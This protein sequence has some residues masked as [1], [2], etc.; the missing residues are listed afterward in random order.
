VTLIG[1]EN[2][3]AS[4]LAEDLEV[5]FTPP[6]KTAFPKLVHKIGVVKIEFSKD[7][8]YK[9]GYDKYE[10]MP[11]GY[12]TGAADASVKVEPKYD[13]VSIEKSKEGKVKATYEGADAADIFF[14]A[15]APA[16]AKP[17][18]ENP[19]AS[20]FDLVITG[21]GINRGETLIEGRVESK[22]GP[23]VAKLG[24]VVFLKV[25]VEAEFYAVSDLLSAPTAVSQHAV[26]KEQLNG[27][28]DNAYPAAIAELKIT[29]CHDQNVNYD[30]APENGILDLIATG[31]SAEE[32]K[33]MTDCAF[34]LTKQNIVCVKDLQ[35]LFALGSDLTLKKTGTSVLTLTSTPKFLTVNGWFYIEDKNG[36]KTAIVVDSFNEPAKTVTVHVHASTPIA[37]DMAF[38]TANQ[39]QILFP[40]NGL[41][42]NPGWVRDQTGVEPLANVIGHEIGHIKFGF[43][44]ICEKANLMYYMAVGGGNWGL[45]HRKVPIAYDPFGDEEQWNTIPGR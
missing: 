19:T 1:T 45:R 5:V 36:Q 25:T 15:A 17:K 35:W 9:G 44:D 6:G 23:I 34:D 4:A 14:T 37:A 13:F 38:T 39:S 29:A 20:P 30:T 3:S 16:K 24:A 11:F 31:A 42:G 41:S 8:T 21:G 26:T 22:T 12:T 28:L 2:P 18:T 10:D 40:L 33:I 7:A 43:K 27:F 32:T